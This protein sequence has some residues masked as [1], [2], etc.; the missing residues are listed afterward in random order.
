VIDDLG[1]SVNLAHP[2]ERIISLAPDLTELLFAA[3]AGD[4]IVGVVQGSDYP[5]AAKKI[6]IVASYNS[7][8]AEAVLAL[9]PDLVVAWKGNSANQ[10][11]VLK[12]LGVAVFISNQRDLS[13]IPKTLRRLG[14]LSNNEKIAE[15]AAEDFASHV[16]QLEKKYSHQKPLSVFFELSSRP[17]MTINK[18][19]WI[20]QMITICGGNNIFANLKTIAPIINIEAVLKEN[21]E[22]ILS[23]QRANWQKEWMVWGQ[24]KAVQNKSLF[25]VNPDSVE[26]AGPR[27][28]AGL[29]AICKA[30]NRTS[31]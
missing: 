9:H 20:N 1:N 10:L 11:E 16:E 17:L 23:S 6:P 12:H 19:S 30:I 8:N 29:D 21:P 24:M 3:G 5:L 28:I 26:R 15:K 31:F 4:K 18:E 27:L 7:L 2:A 13:D 22:V 14:C 25:T